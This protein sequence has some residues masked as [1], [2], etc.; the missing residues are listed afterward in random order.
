MESAFMKKE[1]M[2]TEIDLKEKLGL[3]YTTWNELKIYLND[4]LKN[5]SEEWNYPGKS[6]VGAFE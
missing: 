3:T 5:P 2:P 1:A 6:T 4:N